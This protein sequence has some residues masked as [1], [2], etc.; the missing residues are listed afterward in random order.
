MEDLGRKDMNDGRGQ[1]E[2]QKTSRGKRPVQWRG[3]YGLESG[4]VDGMFALVQLKRPTVP[5]AARSGMACL[6]CWFS[7]AATVD[8][9]VAW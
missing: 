2:E 6:F 4:M 7:L 8:D 3:R 1:R 5:E 9:L